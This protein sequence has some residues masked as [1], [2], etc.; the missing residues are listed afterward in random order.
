VGQ[1]EGSNYAACEA[2]IA[3]AGGQNDVIQL[4]RLQASTQWASNARSPAHSRRAP[5]NPDRGNKLASP[6]VLELWGAARWPM[7][8]SDSAA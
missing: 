4:Y 5:E 1:A 8:L 2:G 3:I 7:V 6:A